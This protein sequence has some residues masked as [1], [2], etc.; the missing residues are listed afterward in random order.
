MKRVILDLE[1]SV[2]FLMKRM[3]KSTNED[4][5]KLKHVL[6]F[7]KKTK[8]DERTIGAET[9]SQIWNF[10]DASH[11][12]HENMRSHTGGL[13]SMGLGLIH[14]KSCSQTMNTKSTTESELV[15]VSEYLPYNVWFCNFMEEQGYQIKENILYQD[16]KSAIL[17]E[18]NGRNLCTVSSS[19]VNVRY[20]WVKDRVD[21]GKI[22]V[23][24]LPTHLMLANFYTKHLMGKLFETMR[25]YIMG[26]KPIE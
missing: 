8:S 25:E 19:N 2:S 24:Y 22:K 4:W 5:N 13:M 18:I 9:L 26:W 21:Q 10:I 23:W 14:G 17:M 16:N 3:S 7:V 6:D 11:A 20:F 15:G 12:V 1:T